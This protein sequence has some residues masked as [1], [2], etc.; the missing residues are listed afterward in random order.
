MRLG[1]EGGQLSLIK[2]LP[3]LRGKG[4]NLS[5]LKRASKKHKTLPVGR[6]NTL[7]SKT[8]VDR[9]LLMKLGII[10]HEFDSVKIVAGGKLDI[11]LTVKIPCS[12]GAK[13][14]IETPGGSVIQA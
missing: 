12:T 14:Q 5:M 6:L 1:F 11:P 8:V 2:R 9:A 4:K 10:K 3:L 7:A 13:V